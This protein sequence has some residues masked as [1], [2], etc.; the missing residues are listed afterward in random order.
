MSSL[1]S[2]T[3]G[4]NLLH[5]YRKGGQSTLNYSG[6]D[7]LVWRIW[8]GCSHSPSTSLF[9]HATA[10]SEVDR[11]LEIKWYTCQCYRSATAQQESRSKAPDD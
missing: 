5:S 8:P 9:G 7:H 4:N 11:Q 1:H 10:Y 3:F 6:S 2:K